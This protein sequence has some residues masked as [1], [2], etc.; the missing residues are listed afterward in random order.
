MNKI[1]TTFVSTP[2]H[3]TRRSVVGFYIF[4]AISA[5]ILGGIVKL[6]GQ[7]TVNKRLYLTNTTG[8]TRTVPSGV[9]VHSTGNITK[10]TAVSAAFSSAVTSNSGSTSGFPTAASIVVSGTDKLLIVTIASD[11]KT[12]VTDVKYGTTSLIRWAQVSGTNSKCE[13]WYAVGLADGTYSV[14]ATWSASVS[15]EATMGVVLLTGVNQTTPLGT[16]G[17]NTN[18]GTSAT[19]S[20]NSSLGDLFI[21]AVALSKNG[22]S[23]TMSGGQTAIINTGTNTVK[24]AVSKISATSPTTSTSYTTSNG[25]WSII[26]V[27]VKGSSNNIT[28]FIQTPAMCSLFTIKSGSTITVFANATVTSGTASGATLPIVVRLLNGATPFLTLTSATNSGLGALNSTGTLTWTGT[29]ASDVTIP[30]STGTVSAEFSS[31]YTTAGIRIDFDASTKISY[32]ELPTSTATPLSYVNINSLGVYDAVYPGGSIISSGST[33]TTKYIRAAVS[34]PFGISDISALNLTING[35]GTLTASQVATSGCTKTYEYAWTPVSAGSSLPINVTAHE[36]TEGTV[37]HTS[38]LSFTV[39]QPSVSVTLT[40]T[41][42]SSGPYTINDNIV[43]NIQITNTGASTINTLPLQDLFS[44][45]CLQYVSTTVSPASVV[46]GTISWTNLAGAGLS[47]GNSVNVSVTLKVIGN[48]DPAN[49]TAKV[50]GARDVNSGLCAT[51]TSTLGI[52]IDQ[53]PVANADQY[54]LSS[55]TDLNILS[56][57]T[58]PDVV[59][60]LSANTGTVT[61]SIYAA[62][63]A[64]KGTATVNPDKTIHFV[65]GTLAENE[66]VYFTYQVCDVSPASYCSTAQVAVLY[67][68]TNNPPV[69]TADNASTS[70]GVAKVIN[71]LANDHDV[72]GNLQTPTI[73]GVPNFGS[74]VVNPDKTVTY[75]PNTGFEGTD[76]FIYQVCDDGC[77]GASQCATSMVTVS[78]VFSYFVCKNSTATFSV[79]AVPNATSYSWTNTAGAT[80]SSST[81][82]ITLNFTGVPAG[83]YSV[84]ATAIDN[85]G[86]GT[87]ECVTV[88]VEDVAASLS[89]IDNLCYGSNNG[90]ISLTPSGGVS[91]YSYNW[92]NGASIQNLSG[93]APGSYLVTITD[94]YSCSVTKS[95]SITQPTALSATAVITNETSLGGANGSIDLTASGGTSGYSYLWSN[96]STAED[97]A[98][99]TYGTYQVTITDINGCTLVKRFTVN[100]I[101]TNTAISSLTKTDVLCI[102]GSSGTVDLEVYGGTGPPFNYTYSWTGP[103][104]FTATTQDLTGLATGTYN[105]TITNG[106]TATGSI[107]VSGP[108]STLTSSAVGTNPSCNGSG[109]GSVASSGAGGTGTYTYHWNTGATSQNISGLSAGTYYVTVTD[110]NGCTSVSS[111][112]LTDPTALTLSGVVTNTACSPNNGGA[113]NIT[114]GGGT[115]PLTFH[116]SNGSSNEDLTALT[117]GNYAVTV[118]DAH[119]CTINETFTIETVCLGIAKTISNG[120]INNQNG[121]YTLTYA[122]RFQNYGNI[123]LTNVQATENLNTSFSGASYS[124]G[125]ILSNDFVVNPSFNGNGSTNLLSTSQT[126][127]VNASG[128][129]YVTL[130]VT[131]GATLGV[132]YNSVSGS[133]ASATGVS[134]T[135]NDVSQNGTNPDSDSDGN[136]GN[137][138]TPTPVTFSENPLIGVAKVISNGPIN[139]GDGTYTLTYTIT[140]RNMGDVPLK[141]V[142]VTDNLTSTFGGGTVVVNNITSAD[143]AENVTYNG[144]TQTNMLLG[145][146]IMQVNDIRT[147]VVTLTVAPSG[148]GPFNNTAV[149]TG[150]GPGG[151][152]T[153]DN[154]QDGYYPDSNNNGTPLDNN[155]PT[156]ATFSEHPSVGLAKRV[157]GTPINN[158]DGTYNMTYEFLAKNTGDVTIHNVQITENL[159]TTF[160]GK[161]V[162]FVSSS[163]SSFAVNSGFSGNGNLL[164]GSDVLSVGQFGT[165]LLT[166]KVTP[167]TNLGPYNNN[168]TALAVSQF[169]ATVSDVSTNGTVVDPEND[170]PGNNSVPTP[171]TFTESPQLKLVKSVDANVNNHD[172]TYSITYGFVF[173]NTGNVP[174]FNL[175]GTDNMAATFTGAASSPT[176]T[177]VHSSSGL[178][179]NPSYNGI[180]DQNLLTGVDNLAYGASGT[181]SVTVTFTAGTKLGIYYNTANASAASLPGTP[182]SATS[183]YGLSVTPT[184]ATVL[185]NPHLGIA[186]NLANVND[187]GNGTYDVTYTILAENMGDVILY[188]V[189]LTDNIAEAFA[190]ATT[191]PTISSI[192]S[193]GITYNPAFNG[194]SNIELLTGTDNL[195]VGASGT[196]TLVITVTPGFYT[197]PFN[198]S[199]LGYGTTPAG[200]IVADESQNGLNPDPNNNGPEDNSDPTPVSFQNVMIGAGK[201]VLTSPVSQ[202]DGSYIV[203]Y[204][205]R[206]RNYGAYDL[207]DVNLYDT[208]TS[209]FGTYTTGSLSAGKYTISTAPAITYITSGSALTVN[210]LYTGEAGSANLLNFNSGDVLQVADSVTMTFSVRFYPGVGVNDFSNQ[211]FATGDRTE[212]GLT[213]RN[214]IDPSNDGLSMDLDKDGIPNE[215]LSNP[216][217]N[218]SDNTPTVFSMSCTAPH[219]N[220]QTAD[221]CSG[222][223]SGVTMNAS[224]TVPASTFNITSIVSNGLTASAGNPITGTGF[225][226]SVLADDVWNNTTGSTVTV[227]YTILPVSAIGCIG[228]PYTVT[229]TIQTLPVMNS[230]SGYT[231]CS[232]QNTNINLTSA[233][234]VTYTWVATPSSGN[235]TNYSDC[236]SSCGSTIS[237]TPANIG[238]SNETVLYT[239]TPHLGTCNGPTQSILIT[240]RPVDLITTCA[241]TRNLEACGTG[242]IVSPVYSITLASSSQ[243]EFEGAP[244]NGQVNTTCGIASVNYIDVITNPVPCSLTINRSWGITDNYGNTETCVQ[245]INIDDNTAP[246]ITC[247]GTV[248]VYANTGLCTASG[249]SLGTPIVSD[250][251]TA[252][253]PTNNFASQWPSGDVPVGTHTVH[254]V[255]TDGCGNSASCDQSLI[256]I[257]NQSPEI[258]CPNAI[259]ASCAA[260][261]QVPYANLTDFA[262]ALPVHGSV[263]DNCGITAT[264]FAMISETDDGNTCPKIV[265]R[266]YSITDI[267]G[268]SSTCS[269]T[270]TVRDVVAPTISQCAATRS[271]EGCDVSVI[272]DP[273]YSATSTISSLSVFN[274]VNNTGITSDGCGIVTVTYQD[275]STGTCP[276]SVARTWTIRDACG[277]STTCVQ[278][279]L[280]TDHTAPSISGTM[281]ELSVNLVEPGCSQTLPTA[282]A[283]VAVLMSQ[284]TNVTA[285]TDCNLVSAVTYA[286]V[287]NYSTGCDRNFTRTYTVADI[288]G[289]TSDITQLIHVNDVTAPVITGTM[290]ALS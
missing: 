289:N 158:H 73:T 117:A 198:N 137:N 221:V 34:D 281:N 160:P 195:A 104:G 68:T 23:I 133:A 124:F 143:L 269:Q 233:L 159:S 271:I 225:S 118:T 186:K 235:V 12:P 106:T 111:A 89:K 161:T 210:S 197:K 250:N 211:M 71:I 207:L 96:G 77:P 176:I 24:N 277:N 81:N 290:T 283:T 179:A 6:E 181:V 279:I 171:V 162:V 234:G 128:L 45:S 240:V 79:P 242:D 38:S 153:T 129:V 154:S 80:G 241:A 5:F 209:A 103:S 192:S 29:V 188:N 149:G 1:F 102:G 147:I 43:Y 146:D 54:C 59:G 7:T 2:S 86:S 69:A 26:G 44:A 256:V 35:G 238:A 288:C 182:V 185:E 109:N 216:N 30:A 230:L 125:S 92:S 156:P 172:L 264:S 169:G 94:K 278:T 32:I 63:T 243:S 49:N 236:S 174:I 33:G 138:S 249:I 41:S 164:S 119:G 194:A 39:V 261:E 62:P 127:A 132:Y 155:D 248:T 130:T 19:V 91:P 15:M 105:V 213:D 227:M 183:Q 157:V 61:V 187:N 4:I 202:G 228:D 51:Q 27:A 36:G 113:I 142:Q 267:H 37:T 64:G 285:I 42:P 3:G 219:L 280:V 286:D 25:E 110:A 247:P 136:P 52:N 55:T 208:L 17:T 205:V 120:P 270:L 237:Q 31:D 214:T 175:Q 260:T 220:N 253:T 282:Y 200:R 114:A 223:A 56:N 141:N 178:H 13:I 100:T 98:G 40:K 203:Q 266:V 239:V 177:Y 58:D 10:N 215:T 252:N 191:T 9:T 21:D 70:M 135:S 275:V 112:A 262:N 60:Y 95:T 99:L 201:K 97:P 123:A 259:T 18:S 180:S 16:A 8:L 90:S 163:S 144:T 107:A 184:P 134:V 78:V 251:C 139:N 287:Q 199:I 166:I 87:S 232:E 212:N 101:G 82:S 140:V 108:G 74:A 66:I 53:L 11:N 151:T 170:G 173:S 165:V 84:C 254:W 131:P 48:C 85:C 217:D 193:S 255:V 72:D 145:T 276:I 204:Q 167:T 265:T 244:N 75:T 83:T 226:G 116:W 189:H 126:L 93:L 65:P 76:T 229:L 273:V 257:D 121:S 47:A 148:L 150:Y 222:V 231:I 115:A 152:L 50:E 268:N 57:D 14:N 272:T 22:G 190:G 28:K 168:A 245:I 46:N 122:I 274:D 258:T 206:A 263:W 196:V 246:S 224:V 218:S 20:G 284:N 67:S 88:T